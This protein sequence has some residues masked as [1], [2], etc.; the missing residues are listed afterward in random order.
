MPHDEKTE[1]GASAGL[2]VAQAAWGD[3]S[4][5]RRGAWCQM[6][7]DFAPIWLG[8]YPMIATMRAVRRNE[9]TNITHWIAVAQPFEAAESTPV[10]YYLLRMC[11]KYKLPMDTSGTSKRPHQRIKDHRLLPPPAGEST[12]QRRPYTSARCAIRST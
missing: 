8:T 11:V 1:A 7:L 10:E 5:E 4:H 2:A 6:Q 9:Y 12:F 3:I